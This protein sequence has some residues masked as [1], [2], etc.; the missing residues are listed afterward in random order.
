MMKDVSEK[1]IWKHVD[2]RS[3][4]FLMIYDDICIYKYMCV[5]DAT[6]VIW[7]EIP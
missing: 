2:W 7:N 3:L 1:T 4:T 5:F 6:Y